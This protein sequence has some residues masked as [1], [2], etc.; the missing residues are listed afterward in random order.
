MFVAANC[1]NSYRRYILTIVFLSHDK[2]LDDI[3]IILFLRVINFWAYLILKTLVWLRI[4]I[5]TSFIEGTVHASWR[6]TFVFGK[7]VPFDFCKLRVFD[8]WI[9]GD[10]LVIYLPVKNFILL[11]WIISTIKFLNDL[12]QLFDYLRLKFILNIWVFQLRV[13]SSDLVL[14]LL[15]HWNF[16]NEILGQLLI[17][18]PDVVTGEISE[19]GLEFVIYHS[20]VFKDPDDKLISQAVEIPIW[21]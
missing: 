15:R 5:K 13:L 20:V 10:D 9:I 18:I 2:L 8:L 21:Q 6:H 11:V 3:I 7:A 1:N 19:L 12:H 14:I 17:E 16:L 4:R